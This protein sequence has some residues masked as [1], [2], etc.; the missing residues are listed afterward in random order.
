MKYAGKEL[1]LENYRAI[2]T[3][4]P[5]DILDEVRSAIFDG[6]PIMPYIDRDPDDLHQIRLAMLETIP[7]PFFVLPAPIL[8]IVRNHA[9]NQGNLNSFRP[10]LKMGL[11]VP[12]LAAVLE[13]TARGYPTTGCDFR[14]MRETQ[15]SLYESALAQ[16]MDIKPY[17]NAGISSDTALRS[18]LNLARPSLARAGLNEEQLHQISRAP[19]LADLPLTRNSQADTLEA[20]ANLYATRIPDTVPGLMQQLSSQNEDGSFQYSGT[21]IARIQEGWEKGTLTRE[22]LMPGLS[23]ATVN[24]RALEANVANQR[25]KHA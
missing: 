9:H 20:L 13:W 7:E 14:Y 23:D 22:L 24:A 19:V 2:L 4:Y 25:H 5:L 18:L 10:F 17:L 11:T 12:V 1:T 6:T 16:G 21:Q 3:G 8:R 15:L